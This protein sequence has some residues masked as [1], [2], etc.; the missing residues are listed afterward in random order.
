MPKI[1]VSD[2]A[3]IDSSPQ[4]V[5]K[6]ILNEYNGV[7]GWVAPALEF[8]P[9]DGKPFNC[10]GAVCDIIGH[11]HGLAAHFSVKITSLRKPN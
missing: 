5:Y 7:T 9:R 6:A 11:S 1:N 4:E 8:K 3:I 2:Q 10:E